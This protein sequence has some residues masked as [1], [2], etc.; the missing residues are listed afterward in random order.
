MQRTITPENRCHGCDCKRIFTLILSSPASASS[1][2]S[3]L[4]VFTENGQVGSRN[5]SNVRAPWPQTSG[6]ACKLMR[7]PDVI[8]GDFSEDY[9]SL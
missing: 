3:L 5:T 9:F 7:T 4:K 2:S 1:A 6:C 8:D